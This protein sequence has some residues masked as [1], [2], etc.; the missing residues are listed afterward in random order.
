MSPKEKKE[1]RQRILARQR[2]QAK[3]ARGRCAPKN[4]L[5]SDRLLD[6]EKE[7]ITRWIETGEDQDYLPEY[8]RHVNWRHVFFN[9]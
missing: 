8:Y 3:R 4:Y 7:A 5:E 1:R 9:Y 2:E 6:V